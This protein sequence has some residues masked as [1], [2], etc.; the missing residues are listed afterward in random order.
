MTKIKTVE[1]ATK[2]LLELMGSVA[3]VEVVEDKKNEAILVN[4]D[5]SDETGL[6]IGRHGET[7]LSIQ[8]VLGMIV[9]QKTGE[10]IRIIVNVG[11]WR[12]KEEAHLKELAVQAAGRAKETGEPQYL[13]NLSSAQRRIIHLFLLEDAEVKTESQGEGKER[14]LAIFKA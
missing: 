10:W 13:Y 8:T 12:E 9:K 11:D 5:S 7:I 2:E 4:L 14:F 3:K 6:L 1:K